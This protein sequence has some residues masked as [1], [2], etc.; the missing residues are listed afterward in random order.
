[1]RSTQVDILLLGDGPSDHDHLIETLRTVHANHPRLGLV[2]LL[3]SYDRNLV[4]NAMRAGVRGLFCRASQ[5][6]RALCRCIT[7][8]QQGQYWANTEQM[9]YVIEALSSAPGTRVINAKGEDLLTPRE[10]QVVN[11]VAE[12]I[13]N[14]EIG[15]Q[16]GIKEN[17]VKK[18]L[19]RTYDKLGVSKRVELVLYALTHR[20]SEK[21]AET[22][23]PSSSPRKAPAPAHLCVGRLEANQ[24]DLLATDPACLL[25]TN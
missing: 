18:S 5:P 25:K 8:V 17:T 3:D 19:L 16:L 14:R 2:L 23:A 22:D 1:M 12:G 15:E 6:F 9:G 13:G 7:V 10:E 21:A 20:G 4:V 11:L 24:V